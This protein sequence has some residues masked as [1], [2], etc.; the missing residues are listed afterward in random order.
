MWTISTAPI[1]RFQR[2]C[3]WDATAVQPVASTSRLATID[4]FTD[5]YEL[6]LMRLAAGLSNSG[7]APTALAEGE[8]ERLRE[9]SVL[10]TT[11]R[12]QVFKRSNCALL[13]V[14]FGMMFFPEWRIGPALLKTI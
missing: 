12:K 11:F 9:A 8:A 1:V 6:N 2:T 14:A 7:A 4:V 13:A 5:R 10:T 3:R